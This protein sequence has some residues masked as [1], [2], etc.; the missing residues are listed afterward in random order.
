M[1]RPPTQSPSPAFPPIH[2]QPAD[3]HARAFSLMP[4]AI[5]VSPR[6]TANVSPPQRVTKSLLRGRARVMHSH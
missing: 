2:Q 4:A 3:R 5:P 6:I 1:Q